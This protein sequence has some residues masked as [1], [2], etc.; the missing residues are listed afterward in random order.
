MIYVDADTK[1]SYTYAQ[2]RST[3]LDFGK[4]LKSV[5]E[6]KKGDVLALYSP[7]CIDTPA[8]MW[9]THWAGGIVSPANPGYTADEL[10]FQLKD[11]GAKA[12][13]TQKS[14]LKTAIEACKK[15]GI[16]E[17]RIILMGD[18][19]DETMKFKHFSHIRNLA[20]TSRYRKAKINPSKDLAFLVYSS[21]TTGHP[22]GVMLSHTNIVSNTCML[23]TGEQGNLSWKGGPNNEGDKILAFLPFFHAYVPHP[24]PYPLYSITNKTRVSPVSSISPCTPA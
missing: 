19:R 11:S 14:F 1:R 16:D 4:G 7:N 12:L 18:E 15:V 13:V 17:D 2:V 23:K 3:A 5:W 8:I 6:W 24:A 21:G 22:K 20:G 9:G 10:A